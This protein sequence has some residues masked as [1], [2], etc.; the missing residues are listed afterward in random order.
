MTRRRPAKLPALRPVVWLLISSVLLAGLS[1]PPARAQDEPP[2][3]AGLGTGEQQPPEDEPELP[4]GL[5]GESS[6]QPG[7][8]PSLPAGLGQPPAEDEPELPAGLGEQ[9]PASGSEEAAQR[10]DWWDQL[11]VSGFWE[12]RGGV[13]TQRDRHQKR[14]SIAETR[15]SLELEFSP[16]EDLIFKLTTDLLYDQVMERHKVNLETGE[17]LL[18]LREASVT[19]SPLEFMD[20]KLGRQVLTWGTG[21]LVFLND[22]FPKDWQ[23]F[24]IG[25]DT[26]YLKAPSDALK[27]SLFSDVANWDIVYT[28]RFDADRFIRGQRIS[29]YN[30]LI[31]GR[32]GRNFIQSP[33]YP[34]RWLRDS[35]WATRVSRLVAG[36]ELAGYGYWGYWKSPGGMKIRGL[37]AA[38]PRLSVYGGSLRG[39]IAGGIANLEV[40]YYDSREDRSGRNPLVDNSQM[41]FL[42][43]YER[44]M[45][46]LASDLT[47][48]MQYY[49]EWM[50]DYDQYSRRQPDFMPRK[51]EVR[52]VLT[53]R[54]TRLLLNQNLT[55]SLFA[56][57]SPSDGD[58]YLRPRVSYKLNDDWTAEVGGN[59][60]FG[61][62]EYTF[63]GQFSR[64]SNVY[65]AL[66]Y[67]F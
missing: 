63:F 12:I 33:D 44:Q 8:E 18:D 59:A 30:P 34:D 60:F 6:E 29:Y 62:N 5:G 16:R 26:D 31:G 22:L 39:Q 64:N 38:F 25:R 24:F 49:V 20:V 3:P 66:R 1:A 37:K 55:L 2:L 35:E 65:V 50:Q 61:T 10:P 28:P 32:A 42:A 19:F 48:G 52:H 9:P 56:F 41:R 46:E 51:D 4:A 53:F 11:D 27:L 58:A 57:Y 14:V 23:S 36:W 13:R 15:L 17:G 7:S 45:P 54:V 47:L 43:G 67:G 40:A 21:D